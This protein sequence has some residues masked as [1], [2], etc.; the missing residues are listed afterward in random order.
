MCQ[1]QCWSVCFGA[2]AVMAA[3]K[4]QRPPPGVDTSTD[5]IKEDQIGLAVT[6]TCRSGHVFPD[7]TTRRSF[8]CVNDTWHTP[9]VHCRR[10]YYRCLTNVIRSDEIRSK[11]TQSQ[12][13]TAAKKQAN[14]I[15]M[16]CVSEFRPSLYRVMWAT[17]V[18]WIRAR[19]IDRQVLSH[20][21]CSKLCYQIGR[22]SI[23]CV[24]GPKRFATS[25]DLNIAFNFDNVLRSS[26]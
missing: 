15:S 11:L 6:R 20:L 14:K 22:M 24:P 19:K 4:C 21:F 10:M 5:T 12:L 13:T 9:L 25:A 23:S 18:S 1:Y 17:Y 3:A 16:F 2:C 8:V 7:G 26:L